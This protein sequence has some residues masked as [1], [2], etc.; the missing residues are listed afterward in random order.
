MKTYTSI[1]RDIRF[2]EP[3]YAF[4]KLDGSQIRAE[5][6]K[7]NKFHK[8]GTRTQMIDETEIRKEH[9]IFFGESIKIVK[10]KY[11]RDLHDIFVSERLQEATCFFE[12]F[13]KNSFAGRHFDE[14]HELVLFDV[15][16]YKKGY[17]LPRQFLKLFGRLDIPKLL[18]YGNANHPFVDSVRESRLDGMT[19]EGVVC[20]M[21][22]YKTP[23]ITDM[24]KVKSTKWLEKLKTLCNGDEKKFNELA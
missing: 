6:N 19:F 9:G 13:G 4:D 22:Q 23:G 21:S 5:W 2:G 20:K 24:F 17:I 12:F 7:K 16:V 15:S 18:Y 11:E 3:I 1:D 8:F 10:D 14:P